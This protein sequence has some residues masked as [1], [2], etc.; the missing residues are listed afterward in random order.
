MTGNNK[1]GGPVVIFTMLLST[2][3]LSVVLMFYL[4]VT[5]IKKSNTKYIF[6][7]Y[8]LNKMVDKVCIKH[9]SSFN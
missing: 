4:F 3:L 2:G 8:K 5:A 9:R 7:V 6:E 1:N